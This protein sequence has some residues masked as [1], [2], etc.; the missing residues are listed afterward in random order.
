MVTLS[1]WPT[2]P[3]SSYS[4]L[5]KLTNFPFFSHSSDAVV[6]NDFRLATTTLHFWVAQ[7]FL[8]ASLSAASWNCCARSALD[9]RA[10]SQRH[11]TLDLA[12]NTPSLFSTQSMRSRSPASFR[13]PFPDLGTCAH[14]AS[15]PS[16]STVFWESVCFFMP[17][18]LGYWDIMD[19][20]EF[21]ALATF[22]GVS[23]SR[24]LRCF[25]ARF[26]SDLMGV[27]TEKTASAS[28][29]SLHSWTSLR[30]APSA[31]PSALLS[32]EPSLSS[33]CCC[34][35]GACAMP[36]ALLAPAPLAPALLAP[37]LR[38]CALRAS[39][40]SCGCFASCCCWASSIFFISS[41]ASSMRL[42]F[43]ATILRI[44]ASCTSSSCI[45]ISAILFFASSSLCRS[46]GELSSPIAAAP[47]SEKSAALFR[48]GGCCV[49]S[50]A[51]IAWHRL[52][53][54]RPCETS[55]A[56]APKAPAGC[57][58]GKAAA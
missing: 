17:C 20:S 7:S 14:A 24:L 29:S 25:F 44:A 48:L 27:A 45:S 12:K 5:M 51:S 35:A 37:A 54:R 32:L 2:G 19:W 49:S 57:S 1:R 31:S 3:P 11:P 15:A 39:A 21:I 42:F 36:P 52:A 23:L 4:I 58:T 22:C 40:A 56:A 13:L 16:V 41:C 53:L 34:V 8:N 26:V 38:A 46:S 33:L 43:S 6:V 55:E 50:A 28:L 30:S 9:L 47:R 18:S 10:R